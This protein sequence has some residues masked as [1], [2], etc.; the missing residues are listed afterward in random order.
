M[1]AAFNWGRTAKSA[2]ACLLIAWAFAMGF[3]T[4]VVNTLMV[5]VFLVFIL[6]YILAGN[7]EY[8]KTGI[9]LPFL[10]F[11]LACALSMY[12]SGDL[13]SS[14]RGLTKVLKNAAVVLVVLHSVGDKKLLRRV[15]YALL[16]GAAFICLDGLFQYITGRDFLRGNL[17]VITMDLKRVSASFGGA[18]DFGVY[19]VSL[20][21]LAW[22]T[23]LYYFK[24][25]QKVLAMCLAAFMTLFLLLTFGRGSLLGLLAA[26]LVFILVK[27]DRNLLVMFCLLLFLLPFVLPNSARVWVK[28]SGSPLVAFANEDRLIMYKTAVE[29]IKAHPV[30]G[31]GVNNF[32]DNFPRY[33]CKVPGADI[34]PVERSYAHNSFLQMW[35]EIGSLGFMMFIWLIWA[36]IAEFRYIY[37]NRKDAFLRNSALGL[38]CGVIGFLING[39]S[40]SNLYYSRL[41]ILFW[42]IFGLAL[43]GKFIRE[44]G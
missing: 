12:N 19:L 7:I 23:A 42:F 33:K 6:R 24:K 15:V 37:R 4:G 5:L 34:L 25:K 18:N 2:L 1:E 11:F 22:V 41:S 38:F 31:V 3:P 32:V 8:R 43:S 14:I 10:F 36:F 30:I 21:P 20:V 13:H 28:Q 26:F 44:E 27:K 16:L 39:L 40:E 9:L 29:M 17:V 35:A